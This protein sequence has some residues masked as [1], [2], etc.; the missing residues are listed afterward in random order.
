MISIKREVD[1]FQGKFY[2]YEYYSLEDLRLDVEC[3]KKKR[4]INVRRRRHGIR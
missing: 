4:R 1:V 3:Q 2:V